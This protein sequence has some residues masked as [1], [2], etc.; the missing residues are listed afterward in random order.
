MKVVIACDS[1]KEALAAREVCAA[2][3]RGVRRAR[4]AA[5]GDLVPLAD[6]GEGTVATLV[7]AT[8]G[9]IRQTTVVG[10]L[11]EPV[12][13]EWGL[14]GPEGKIAVLE[15][16]AASG[17]SLV[18]PGRRNPLRTTTYG[19]GQLVLAA[20]D[21]GAREIIIGIGGSATNDGGTGAA[22]A[23]GVRFY[24][25]DGRLCSPGL[26]GG[27]LEAIGRLDLRQRRG[28]Y[29]GGVRRG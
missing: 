20:L 27:G 2:V 17:L 11:G 19:T 26:T 24:D 14:L 3:G 28:G 8:G 22:Q 15:M 5:V 23:A 25:T 6:G 13:A 29:P 9:T 4:P 7:A 18:P 12:S 1:F 21:A 10:P 16:A